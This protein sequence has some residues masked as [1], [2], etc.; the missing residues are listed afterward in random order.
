MVEERETREADG[1]RDQADETDLPVGELDQPPERV[2]PGARRG[3]RED[4][5]DDQ[6]E[7]ERRPERFGHARYFAGAAAPRPPP[8][9]R[10]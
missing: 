8:P 2:A 5:F 4:T 6:H 9:W 1:D 10:K 7:R 3:E